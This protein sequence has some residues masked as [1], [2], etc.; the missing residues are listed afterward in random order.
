M[1]FTSGLGTFVT[2]ALSGK[3]KTSREGSNLSYP[4][5]ASVLDAHSIYGFNS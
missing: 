1:A 4:E 2:L 3:R 5:P